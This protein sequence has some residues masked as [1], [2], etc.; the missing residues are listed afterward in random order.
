MEKKSKTGLFGKLF[1]GHKTESCCSV[2]FEEIP[3]NESKTNESS[4]DK[5]TGDIDKKNTGCGCNH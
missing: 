4:S 2:E 5:E 3:K 1:G